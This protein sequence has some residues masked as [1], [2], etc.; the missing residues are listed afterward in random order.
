VVAVKLLDGGAGYCSTPRVTVPGT[1]ARVKVKVAFGRN[2]ATNGRVRSLR[3][4]TVA[5]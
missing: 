5:G 4:S 2:L 3:L 1:G